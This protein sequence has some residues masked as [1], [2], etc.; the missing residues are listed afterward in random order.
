MSRSKRK[1][2]HIE[3]ALK[4][5]QSRSSGLDDL[6][7][8]HQSFPNI[9]VDDVVLNTKID[10]LDAGSPIYINAMT[11][12][13]GKATEGINRQLA[14]VA[15]IFNIPMA[16][17]SQ[18]SAIRDKQEQPSYKVVRQ[19]HPRGIVFAN[20]GSE[21]TVEQAR[22][23]VDML[24]AN[25]L[26]IHM[27][28]I[29]ELVMPEGDRD[30]KGALK[31]IEAIVH[32]LDVPVIVKEVGFGMSRETV[33]SLQDIGVKIV[34]IGGFGGTNFSLVENERRDRQMAFFD[35]WGIPTSVSIAEANS[36]SNEMT[37]LAS[38]GIQNAY[39][40]AKAI[41]LGA[42]AVGMAGQ[43][44]RWLQ[45]DGMDATIQHID[46]M[47]LDLKMIMTA[48]GSKDIKSLKNV[49]LV[50]T[51]KTKEWLTERRI[52]TSTFAT[53]YSH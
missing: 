11:G 9:G 5:G 21:A 7:F 8:I 27:N 19:Y 24:E 47:L 4:T 29:Q 15:N 36:V 28:V 10:N 17:G 1:L 49:P 33:I 20:V 48:L 40:I 30:F 3:Y 22:F 44:L 14:Q 46:D 12:G 31:R 35:Q 45:E 18:M 26:Q 37:L 53:R 16:V 42:N 13:G 41:A 51:G 43:V 23:C 25:A 34:D 50:I 2:D 32:H 39:D 38:G 6:K 52:D